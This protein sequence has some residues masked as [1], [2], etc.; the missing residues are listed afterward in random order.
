MLAALFSR[1]RRIAEVVF[2]R[3]VLIVTALTA[4]AL[5]GLGGLSAYFSYRAIVAEHVA[6]LR[7]ET[8]T[9]FRSAVDKDLYPTLAQLLERGEHLTEVSPI[10]GGAYINGVGELV[11]RFG[12][13]PALTWRMAKLER[14]ESL[15]TPSGAA[16]DFFI[17]PS[18]IELPQSAILRVDLSDTWVAVSTELAR[19]FTVLLG[20][21]LAGGFLIAFAISSLLLVPLMR[22]RRSIDF[23]LD[24]PANAIQYALRK[25]RRDEVG[26]VSRAI[27]KLYF[28]LSNTFE[29]DLG[30]ALAV[31]ARSPIC[32]ILFDENGVIIEANDAALTTL[33]VSDPDDIAALDGR[34]LQVGGEDTTPMA[35]IENGPFL[36]RGAIRLGG[37]AERWLPVLIGGNGIRRPDGT[38]R[39]FFINFAPLADFYAQIDEANDKVDKMEAALLKQRGYS[40]EVRELLEASLAMLGAN[41]QDKTVETERSIMPDRLIGAWYRK[42]VDN[43]L[44]SAKSLRHGYLPPVVMPEAVATRIFEYALALVRGRSPYQEPCILIT[45]QS[46]G[47][48]RFVFTFSEV[49]TDNREDLNSDV[50]REFYTVFSGALNKV[51]T[52]GGGSVVGMRGPNRQNQLQIELPVDPRI[53]GK[54]GA[55]AKIDTSEAP[56]DKA[57]SGE[58]DDTGEER[59]AA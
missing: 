31:Q 14:T 28:V 2:S 21:M 58:N 12:E 41:A 38:I 10:L 1:L 9:A 36:E 59:E 22:M 44:M 43:G 47:V 32:T 18:E 51:V 27:D 56:P 11:G 8:V 29:E 48:G 45:A 50:P 37:G 15:M 19:K 39:R 13:R 5:F 52:A 6:E 33:G 20:P 40:L 54:R 46:G 4:L 42:C 57:D 34:F 7:T 53:A 24:D 30:N 55:E 35:A 3:S 49:I 16:M 17:R 26:R 23:V 25:T